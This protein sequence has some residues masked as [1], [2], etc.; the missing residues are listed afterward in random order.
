MHSQTVE[1]ATFADDVAAEGFAVLFW[2]I[3]LAA[4]D[5]NV[6]AHGNRQGVHHVSLLRVP[7]LENFGQHI[8]EHLPERRVYGVQPAV[9]ATLG[10]RLWYVSVLVQKRAARL[11]VTAEECGG[12]K[13]YGHHL[14][15]GQENL[16]IVAVACGL[17]ELLAQVVGGNHSIV[18]CVLP[19][20]REGFR[21]PSDREDIVYRDRG[22]LGLVIVKLPPKSLDSFVICD[23]DQS[24]ASTLTV[25]PGKRETRERSMRIGEVPDNREGI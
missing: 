13:S 22:Q 3:E 10:D 15:G 23:Q 18:Q 14:G 9:E 16:R 7:V 2:R 4:A 1:V 17:Q 6:V 21:R 12:R 24:R 8:E 11:D 25:Y 5:A 20:Q 19:I